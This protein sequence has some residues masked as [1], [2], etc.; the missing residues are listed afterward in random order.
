M[1][2][3][4]E[5]I[6]TPRQRELIAVAARLFAKHGYHAVGINDIS[7]E[8]G[9][10]GPA[11]YRHYPSKEALL[12]ACLDDAITSHLEA[13]VEVVRAVSD[14]LDALEA[15]IENHVDFVFDQTENIQVWRTEFRSLPEADRHR[16]RYLQRLYTE[17]WVRIVRELRTDLD[18][19]QVRT[20]CQGAISLIQSATE[21]HNRL[22]REVV[23]PTLGRMALH[24]LIGTPAAALPKMPAEGVVKTSSNGKA[25]STRSARAAAN[26]EG[27]APVEST[28]AA[29]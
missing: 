22:P 14:P 2:A 7:G 16:L 6:R 23:G 26:H 21:F 5:E 24:A 27:K 28:A 18:V 9:L 8:L 10:T 13:V 25:G 15:V 29:G 1:S 17:E 4:T 20:M 12:I 3:A 11:F 19:E